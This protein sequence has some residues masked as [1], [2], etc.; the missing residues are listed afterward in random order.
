[1][2]E[3]PSLLGLDKIGSVHNER[4]AVGKQSKRVFFPSVH[5]VRFWLGLPIDIYCD[6]RGL[7]MAESHYCVACAEFE[8]GGATFLALDRVHPSFIAI[9]VLLKSLPVPPFWV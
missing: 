9:H 3:A 7:L 1:M 8:L 6:V 5:V 2:V 4:F